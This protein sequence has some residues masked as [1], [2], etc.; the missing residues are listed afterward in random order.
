MRRTKRKKDAK[1]KKDEKIQKII[2]EKSLVT[3]EI[4]S[5]V[6][7]SKLHSNEIREKHIPSIHNGRD[8]MIYSSHPNS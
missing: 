7:V 3:R 1:Q 2:R 5:F 6:C 8:L 4:A